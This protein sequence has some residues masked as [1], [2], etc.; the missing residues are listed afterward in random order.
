M[1]SSCLRFCL[2]SYGGDKVNP[3]RDERDQT[4]PIR[5]SDE[6]YFFAIQSVKVICHKLHAYAFGYW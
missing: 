3:K 2:R 6:P 1:P 4:S 5:L